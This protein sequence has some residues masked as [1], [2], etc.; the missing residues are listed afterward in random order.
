[1]EILGD[2]EIILKNNLYLTQ[3]DSSYCRLDKKT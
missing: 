3:P 2:I 1:M